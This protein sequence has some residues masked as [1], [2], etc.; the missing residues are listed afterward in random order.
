M[1]MRERIDEQG[2]FLIPQ[3][4]RESLDLNPGAVVEVQRS[5]RGITVTAITALLHERVKKDVL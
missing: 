4:L 2:R 5:E 1:R 3:S